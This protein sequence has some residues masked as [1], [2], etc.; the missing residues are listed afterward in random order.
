MYLNEVHLSFWVHHIFLLFQF[1]SVGG[2]QVVKMWKLLPQLT[3]HFMTMV[4]KGYWSNGKC[5]HKPS[6]VLL[7]T[8][9]DFDKDVNRLSELVK[10]NIQ[11]S[12][13]IK[14]QMVEA[15]SQMN[16]LFDHK[17]KIVD[18]MNKYSSKRSLRKKEK[19]WRGTVSERNV[20]D[21]KGC[22][23]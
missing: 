20:G 10:A 6:S 19:S 9:Q 5:F 13:I 4:W 21:L 1:D 16:K 18:I 22:T 2:W 7:F 14:D 23:T 3:F 17:G 11:R 12:K 15:R 8:F